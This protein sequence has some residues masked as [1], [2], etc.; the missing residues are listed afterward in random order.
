ML[1]RKGWKINHKLVLR[2]LRENGWLVRRRQRKRLAAVPRL[3]PVAP[4]RPNQAWAM[5]FVSDSFAAAGRFRVLCIVDRYTRECLLTE[6]DTSLTGHRVVAVLNL[7]VAMRGRPETIRVDN[8]PE[9]ISQALDSWA[10][11]KGVK[12]HFI[13][14]GKPMNRPGFPGGS[15]C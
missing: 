2:L 5:D 3:D 4:T 6:V 10:F 8:G 12:L 7:L 14:P 1:R 11:E 15:N 9:F 13:R